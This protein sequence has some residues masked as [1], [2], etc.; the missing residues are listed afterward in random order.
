MAR[1][2]IASPDRFQGVERPSSLEMSHI[3]LQDATFGRLK[4]RHDD[5]GIPVQL[6][7]ADG[8][9]ICYQRNHLP[10]RPRW[11]DGKPVTSVSLDPGEFLLLDLRR[12]YTA[13]EAGDVDCVSMF[14]PHASI[15]EFHLENDLAPFSTLRDRDVFGYSDIIVRNLMECFVPAFERPEAASR[16][17]LDQLTITLLSH[18]TMFYGEQ[19]T[20]FRA[21]KGGLAPRQERRVKDLLL[22][23]LKGDIGLDVLAKETGLSRAH[24]ARSFKISTGR[25]PMMWLQNQ[26]LEKAVTLLLG[27]SL[28]IQAIADDCG[29]AD[30]SHLTKVFLKRFKASPGEWRRKHKL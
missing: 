7:Q 25:S 4:W 12:R 3:T 21:V 1:R 15:S 27:T 11:I 28:T 17:F 22:A 23:N 6:E 24:L 14:A 13:V 2:G 30:H 18:L 19:K 16:L 9:M 29:F 5:N 20:E 26:R 10:A 8:Y